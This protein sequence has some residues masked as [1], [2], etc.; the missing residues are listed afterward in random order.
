MKKCSVLK[1]VG[2]RAVFIIDKN[3]IVR[4]KWVSDDPRKEPNYEEIKKVLSELK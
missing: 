1:N 4:Y 3:G 2:K